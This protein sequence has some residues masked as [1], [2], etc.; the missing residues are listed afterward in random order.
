MND[1]T[2]RPFTTSEWI[3][4]I[5]R[6]EK[7]AGIQSFY[8]DTVRAAEKIHRLQ[9]QLRTDREIP[10]ELMRAFRTRPKVGKQV[11][12]MRGQKLCWPAVITDTVTHTARRVW[13]DNVGR[14]HPKAQRV[15]YIVISR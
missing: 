9:Q 5:E 14:G 1:R 8:R 15:N 12:L 4:V 3:E 13:I 11:Y 7:E 10:K 6:H 2:N